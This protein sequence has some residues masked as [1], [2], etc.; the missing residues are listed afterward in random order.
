MNT[1]KP[2]ASSRSQVEIAMKQQEKVAA[3]SLKIS[4]VSTHQY[5]G[6]TRPSPRK[7]TDPNSTN[8]PSFQYIS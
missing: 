3:G 6:Q 4:R 1:P 2:T 8:L 7:E 5:A